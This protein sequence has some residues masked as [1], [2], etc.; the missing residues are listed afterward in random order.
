MDLKDKI[1]ELL[2]YKKPFLFVDGFNHVDDSSISGYYTFKEDESF[3]PGHF[4]ENPITPGVIL[5]E[6]AAQ[7]GLVGGGIYQLLKQEKK[8]E[9][10]P[11]FSS[12]EVNFLKPVF[13]NEKVIVESKVIYFRFSKL[14]CEVVM[15]NEKGEKVLNGHLSGFLTEKK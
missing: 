2:P 8:E 13:P 7:I 10:I 11:V 1:V 3:Y 15:T 14:K 4:P 12:A 5:T 9:V 6:T